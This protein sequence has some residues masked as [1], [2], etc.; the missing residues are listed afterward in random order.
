MHAL[1]LF[2]LDSLRGTIR[3]FT[4]ILVLL[5]VVLAGTFFSLFE[6]QR[7]LGME[8]T[9]LLAALHHD[10]AVVRAWLETRL[11]NITF[12]AN[13]AP[14]RQG[15]KAFLKSSIQAYLRV[16]KHV[17]TVG[18]INTDGVVD[19]D[20]KNHGGLFLGDRGYVA[21]AKAGRASIQAVASSRGT[22]GPVCVL[23]TPIIDTADR[24]AGALFMPVELVSLDYI[25]GET[26]LGLVNG[27]VLLTDDQGRILAPS[28]AAATD[29]PI[30]AALLRQL[31]AT[32]RGAVFREPDGQEVVGAVLPLD[33][34]NW[35]LVREVPTATVLSGY[36][37]QTLW[38]ALG[39]LATV[40][41]MTPLVL[42]LC[43]RLERPLEMLAAYARE[44]QAQRYEL[45]CSTGES[46]ADM[47]RE[48]REL[49]EAF[50]GMAREVRRHIEESERLGIQDPLTGLYN[51]RFLFAGGTKLVEA[52]QRAKRPCSCLMLDV[53]HFKRINDTYGHQTG[54]QALAHL[55][56]IIAVCARAA[57]LVARYGGEEFAV[58]LTGATRQQGRELAERIRRALATHPCQVGGH[59]LAMTISIG[60]AE[61]RQ[62]VQFGSGML[63]DLLARADRAMYRA[64]T[65]GR[66][67][68]MEEES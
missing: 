53:D 19:F 20:F 32:G 31:P 3:T 39:G 37:R 12:L 50:C 26:S 60:V 62:E 42:R 67:R 18:H 52:A 15:D 13:Q 40:L 48:M 21:E 57:D 6:R 43:R 5:P 2:G 47:P 8:Q 23:C 11:E 34:G 61:A 65:A 36:W 46:T 55:A 33:I 49:Y 30:A 58:L 54:D 35:L 27:G 17:Y 28:Q 14:V 4:F 1:R 29:R 59:V 66:D 25:L 63:D 45:A 56:G 24:Y 7:I 22:G 68:V 38:V 41:L 44:L 51:R 10:R 9:H 16:H 64:K